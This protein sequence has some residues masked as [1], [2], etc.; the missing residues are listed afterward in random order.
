MRQSS[1]RGKAANKDTDADRL[2]DLADGRYAR[3]LL[4]ALVV[5]VIGETKSSAL[6]KE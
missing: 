6:N 1:Q 2:T 5:L 3:S 4:T